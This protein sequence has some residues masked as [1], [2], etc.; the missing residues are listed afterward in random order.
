MKNYIVLKSK[1]LTKEINCN[2]EWKKIYTERKKKR[3][4]HPKTKT[5]MG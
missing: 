3:D 4:I 5:N 2:N 1:R